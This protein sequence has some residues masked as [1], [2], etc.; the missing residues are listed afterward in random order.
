VTQGRKQTD[1]NA[2]RN[3][4]S[5][6]IGWFAKT[7]RPNGDTRPNNSKL[8]RHHEPVSMDHVGGLFVVN[9]V[10]RV[11]SIPSHHQK[12]LAIRENG[13]GVVFCQRS[14]RGGKG[15]SRNKRQFR[16][17]IPEMPLGLPY[18]KKKVVQH[19]ILGTVLRF[20]NG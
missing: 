18:T 5:G 11:T 13:V 14:R 19:P 6:E 7:G 4:T 15:S 17:K 1:R 2:C 3:I 9:I 20:V 16:S 10:K 8:S 12:G